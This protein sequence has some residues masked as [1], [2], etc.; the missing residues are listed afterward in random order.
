MHY[1]LQIHIKNPLE[2]TLFKWYCNHHWNTPSIVSL[3]I[4]FSMGIAMIWFSSGNHHSNIASWHWILKQCHTL[5]SCWRENGYSTH[6]MITTEYNNT[7][8]ITTLCLCRN[9]QHNKKPHPL[10]IHFPSAQVFFK[11]Q[12]LQDH[13]CYIQWRRTLKPTPIIYWHVLPVNTL[14][15]DMI[16]VYVYFKL[17]FHK[18]RQFVLWYCVSCFCF[19]W[20]SSFLKILFNWRV[21]RNDNLV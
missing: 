5:L 4:L 10:C 6:V 7:C 3:R 2:T 19:C 13:T 20:F 17:L 15:V 14:L 11:D 1:S 9:H 16:Y 18:G 21:R 12:T 8:R